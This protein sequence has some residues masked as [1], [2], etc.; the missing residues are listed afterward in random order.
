MSIWKRLLR[1]LRR[2]SKDDDGTVTVEFVILFPIF[3]ITL[4]AGYE[5]GYYTVSSAMME[6]GLDLT[7][8]DIRL[9][10]M[11]K[12]DNE[13][14]RSS[15]CTYARY[16]RNCED[17]IHIGL[18]PVDARAFERPETVADCKDIGSDTRPDTTFQD[19]GE[20]ELMLVRACVSVAPVFP[21]SILSAE[22]KKV[23]GDGYALISTAAFVNEPN[24]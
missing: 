5:I 15:F 7:V 2:H 19:G 18:E 24:T 14:V 21:T 4:L 3:V 16:I 10:R 8:R 6:R 1:P 11:P 9:G 23:R 13:T 22:L 17:N 20:N 12:V